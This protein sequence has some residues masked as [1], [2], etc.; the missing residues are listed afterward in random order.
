MGKSRAYCCGKMQMEEWYASYDE[1]NHCINLCEDYSVH[2]MADVK[3][4]PWCAK[5]LKIE[6]D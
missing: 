2:Y 1:F 5:E 3:Y 4:C 6:V